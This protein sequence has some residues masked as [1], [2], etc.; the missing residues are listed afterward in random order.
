MIGNY[1]SMPP[2]PDEHNGVRVWYESGECRDYPKAHAVK[3]VEGALV[4]QEFRMVEYPD[5]SERRTEVDLAIYES[6]D[7]FEWMMKKLEAEK[8]GM[9]DGRS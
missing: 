4:V 7:S 3:I 5:H 6:W 8:K 9:A 2:M 1:A